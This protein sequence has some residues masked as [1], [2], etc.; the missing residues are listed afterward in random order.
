MKIEIAP[1]NITIKKQ[2]MRVE[3]CKLKLDTTAK[4]V[5]WAK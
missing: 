3:E 1:E 2:K 4:T 5:I